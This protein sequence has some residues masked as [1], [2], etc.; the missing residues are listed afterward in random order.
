MLHSERCGPGAVHEWRSLARPDVDV[1]TL[2][3]RATQPGAKRQPKIAFERSLTLCPSAAPG[4]AEAPP[5]SARR[6]RT[7]WMVSVTRGNLVKR[8]W[9]KI[10]EVLMLLS[11]GRRVDTAAEGGQGARKI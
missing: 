7:Q 5:R 8:A 1:A 6:V 10:A 4:L 9:P 3:L 2:L 11:A